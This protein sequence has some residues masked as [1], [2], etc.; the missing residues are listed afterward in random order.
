MQFLKNKYKKWQERKN[1]EK[2]INRKKNNMEDLNPII[3][4]ITLYMNDVKHSNWNKDCQTE[5]LKNY[6][7]KYMFT[8][9]KIN[10]IWSWQ[11]QSY[12]L[13]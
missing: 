7:F 11:N 10:Y 2:I 3:L 1:K 9:N 13:P 4:A 5:F 12:S 6:C 8:S